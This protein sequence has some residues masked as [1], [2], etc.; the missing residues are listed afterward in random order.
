MGGGGEGRWEEA[1]ANLNFLARLFR[2]TYCKMFIGKSPF[3]YF[4]LP[5]APEGERLRLPN[6]FIFPS[7]FFFSVSNLSKPLLT[8]SDQVPE[9]SIACGTEMISAKV[10][11]LEFSEPYC[12]A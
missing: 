11:S 4:E 3:Y 10:Q 8:E 2:P 12:Q 1:Q 7:F 5:R 9:C 6:E